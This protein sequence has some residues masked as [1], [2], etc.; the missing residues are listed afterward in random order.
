MKFRVG[1]RVCRPI[2]IYDEESYLKFGIVTKVYSRMDPI[3]GHY[4]E[5]YEVKW[6]EPLYGTRDGY[7][8][9]GLSLCGDFGGF[10]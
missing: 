10:R 3:L 7:L 2:D 8:P 4:P 5:L 6:D 9:N 1:D